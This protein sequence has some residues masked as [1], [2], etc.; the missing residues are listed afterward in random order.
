MYEQ[1]DEP[2][3]RE[4]HIELHQALDE[5]VADW[6]QHT[7]RLLRTSSIMDLVEWSHAQTILPT[8]LDRVTADD[9]QA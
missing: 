5:L 4:R 1:L 3:H 6:I 9:P 7:H 8:P 2:Q